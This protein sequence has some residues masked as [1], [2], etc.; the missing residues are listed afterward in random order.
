MSLTPLQH[1]TLAVLLMHSFQDR[2]K[3]KVTD[4]AQEAGS[5]IGFSE[6]TV[7]KYYKEYSMGSFPKQGKGNTREI[8]FSMKT[9]DLM[10]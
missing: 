2:Q 7:R 3:M 5:I 6:R 1:K 4:A 9:S 10:H 8:A